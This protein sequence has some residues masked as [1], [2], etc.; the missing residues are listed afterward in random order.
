[1]LRVEAAVETHLHYCPGYDIIKAVVQN[2]YFMVCI[3]SSLRSGEKG[4]EA[5][6]HMV[7]KSLSFLELVLKCHE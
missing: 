2:Q 4:L 7:H 3:L 6:I 5:R 1:M